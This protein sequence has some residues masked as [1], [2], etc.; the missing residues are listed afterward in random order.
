[1]TEKQIGEMT[2]EEALSELENI[3][4]MLE[5][6]DTPLEESIKLYE[7]GNQLK[8][9]CQETLTMAEEKVE[10]IM[11]DTQGRPSGTSPYSEDAP[12]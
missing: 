6:G 5:S 1:M 4:Q 12:V 11:L 2:F 10:K 7:R 8:Q 9:R 3:V